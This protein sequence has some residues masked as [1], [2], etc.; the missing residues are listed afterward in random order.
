MSAGLNLQDE[1]YEPEGLA[2]FPPVA[3]RQFRNPAAVGRD[4]GE[5][6]FALGVGLLRRQLFR[7][8][9]ISMSVIDSR[10]IG[11]DDGIIEAGFFNRSRIFF[12]Q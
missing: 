11:N 7:E 9:C 5:L 8:L 12:I 6:C 2:G 3:G 1:L 4:L 10:I